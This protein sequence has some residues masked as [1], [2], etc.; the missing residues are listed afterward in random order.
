MDDVAFLREMLSIPSPSGE[1]DAVAEWLVGQM[2]GRGFHTRRDEAGN[3]VGELGDPEGD[4][5]RWRF[6]HRPGQQRW[7]WGRCL[8]SLAWP[9]FSGGG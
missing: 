5:S 8:F 4:H 2:T 6:P 1:E 7:F 3:V 9:S